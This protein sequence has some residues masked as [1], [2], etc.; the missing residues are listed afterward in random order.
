[1]ALNDD[2]HLISTLM[3][4]CTSVAYISVFK[5]E[6]QPVSSKGPFIRAVESILNTGHGLTISDSLVPSVK[7]SAYIDQ[8]LEN[9][10]RA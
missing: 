1:M 7:Q 8:H 2:G 9:S 3:L 5:A 6:I 10:F 4:D